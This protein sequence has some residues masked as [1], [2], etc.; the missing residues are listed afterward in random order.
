MS[1]P[2]NVDQESFNNSTNKEQY[3]EVHN[4]ISYP[5]L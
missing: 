5:Y 4:E 3:G 1:I 2:G